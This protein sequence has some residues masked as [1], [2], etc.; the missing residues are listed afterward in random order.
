MCISL[1]NDLL[2][3]KAWTRIRLSQWTIVAKSSD[4]YSCCDQWAC[5]KITHV[6]VLPA[7]W[8][9]SHVTCEVFQ[10]HICEQFHMWNV[11]H[12]W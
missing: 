12:M 6:R 8:G 11:F 3:Q 4:D 1:A 5:V 2:L 7:M 10:F 9:I